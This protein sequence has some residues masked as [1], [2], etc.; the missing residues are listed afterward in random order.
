M[1][2]KNFDKY[3]CGKTININRRMKEHKHDRWSNYEKRIKKFGVTQ[4]TRCML[5]LK[6]TGG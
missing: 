6:Y 5:S 3:Y 1:K 2:H 4:F